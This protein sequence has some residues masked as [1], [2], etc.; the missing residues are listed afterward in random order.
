[1]AK[2]FK[3]EV[4]NQIRG[5]VDLFGKVCKAMDVTPAYLPV[6]L[7]RNGNSVNQYSIVALV[8]DHLGKD[9]DELLEEQQIKTQTH[10]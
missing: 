2:V 1:M 4:L 5:D 3:K 7:A 8:A 6:A 9:P 10:A